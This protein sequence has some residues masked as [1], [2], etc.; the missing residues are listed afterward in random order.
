MKK[1]QLFIIGILLCGNSIAQTKKEHKSTLKQRK[2]FL[3]ESSY[4]FIPEGTF[5]MGGYE[6]G[7][8]QRNA[9]RSRTVHIDSF[10]LMKYEVSNYD[11]LSFLE[12]LHK[13]T[14]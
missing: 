11:Y 5:N 7:H 14:G 12:E 10:F 4:A 1:L 13:T 6:N 2:A 3:K 9:A 8:V